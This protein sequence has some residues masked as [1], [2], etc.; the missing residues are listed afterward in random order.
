M[1]KLAIMVT[2]SFLLIAMGA[3]LYS[4]DDPYE[5]RYVN[6]SEVTEIGD[7]YRLEYDL[8]ESSLELSSAAIALCSCDE[9]VRGYHLHNKTRERLPREELYAVHLISENPKAHP[10]PGAPDVE[11]THA[12]CYQFDATDVV[13]DSCGGTRVAF[14]VEVDKRAPLYRH[15]AWTSIVEAQYPDLTLSYMTPS[16]QMCIALTIVGFVF[17]IASAV[18]TVFYAV[19]THEPENQEDAKDWGLNENEYKN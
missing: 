1:L 8:P 12:C 19:V 17:F 10:A 5:Q 2:F 11:D 3:L 4:L 15:R 18:V 16:T 6:A 14:I 9:T 7:G 13:T